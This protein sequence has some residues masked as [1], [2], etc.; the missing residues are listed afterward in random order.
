MD[1]KNGQAGV[2]G[3]GPGG[4][5]G[6]PVDAVMEII[7]GI[8]LLAET[9]LRNFTMA[10]QCAAEAQAPA[11]RLTLARDLSE[12]N[13]HATAQVAASAQQIAQG[14]ANA[15]GHAAHV[16]TTML[17][18]QSVDLGRKLGMVR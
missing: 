6:L 10:Q 9:A 13:G 5:G 11:N 7:G 8:Q 17:I 18:Q 2:P 3:N 1:H 14:K 16:S 4:G 12:A 15:F